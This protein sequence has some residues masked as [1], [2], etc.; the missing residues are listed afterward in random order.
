MLEESIRTGIPPLG[1]ARKVAQL[2]AFIKPAA[3]DDLVLNKIKENTMEYMIKNVKTLIQHCFPPT[4]VLVE[5][6]GPSTTAA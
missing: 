5:R 4:S 3:P 6:L 2:T 1:M